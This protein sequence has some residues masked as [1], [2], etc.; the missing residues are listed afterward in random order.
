[1]TNLSSDELMLGETKAGRCKKFIGETLNVQNSIYG[2]N[3][4]RYRI[5]V[6]AAHLSA[7]ESFSK[8]LFETDDLPYEIYKRRNIE[9]AN[10]LRMAHDIKML[11]TYA[12]IYSP[13]LSFPPDFDLFFKTYQQH[14]IRHYSHVDWEA[15][16][17]EYRNLSPLN[18][19]GSEHA[20]IANNFVLTLREAA[21]K[22]RLKSRMSDWLSG[23]RR[24]RN[25]LRDFMIEMLEEHSRIMVVDVVFLYRK[26]A[27]KNKSEAFERGREQQQRAE[28]EY[29]AYMQGADFHETPSRWVSLADVK[30][31]LHH[32]FN[33]MRNKRSL[34]SKEKF[35]DYFGRIEYSREAGYHVH[36]CF[37]YKGSKAQHDIFY[38]HE[39]GKYW[40]KITAGRGYY[41][42]CNAKAAAGGY[43][44]VGI[45]I[46]EHD[47]FDK[48]KHLWTAV[49]YFVKASQIVRVKQTGKEQMVLHGKRQKRQGEKPGRP[50]GAGLSG[51]EYQ[52]KLRE[53]FV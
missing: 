41:F 17:F 33:N 42:S 45:G 29:Q 44:N 52:A 48:I 35:I 49:D 32:F 21:K 14:P 39:I 43:K 46:V 20:K 51:S 22:E 23:P 3:G 8:R 27:C 18:E 9:F 10:T 15:E 36:V 47:D 53:I 50:R 28:R 7:L 37:F 40:E 16:E 34:F 19:V 24:N 1:M 31:D 26:A 12:R 25:Y 38:S 13:S 30:E 11:P 2:N 4:E 6:N 5:P